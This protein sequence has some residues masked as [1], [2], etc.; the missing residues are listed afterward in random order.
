[1]FWLNAKSSKFISLRGMNYYACMATS[2]LFVL[3]KAFYCLPGCIC[4]AKH[5]I[6]E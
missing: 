5:I 2:K 6:T 1:M 4:I 3:Q